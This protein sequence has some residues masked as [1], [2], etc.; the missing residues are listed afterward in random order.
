MQETRITKTLLKAILVV[1]VILGFTS[2]CGVMKQLER[3][4]I[5]NEA[6][7]Q[8]VESLTEIIQ[9]TKPKTFRESETVG[10][11]WK[12]IVAA[13]MFISNSLKTVNDVFTFIDDFINGNDPWANLWKRIG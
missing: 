12:A 4:E 11:S 10:D 9:E 13:R 7:T 3:L 1:V 8:R 2:G 6:L 5:Q